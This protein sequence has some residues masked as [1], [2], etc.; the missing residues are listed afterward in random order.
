[1]LELE[2][3]FEVVGEAGNGYDLMELL[4]THPETDLVLL[5]LRMPDMSGFEALQKISE[6]DLCVKTVIMSM[7]DDPVYVTRAL[8]LGAAG[9]I[10][11]STDRLD[12][13]RALRSAMSGVPYVQGELTGALLS[14]PSCGSKAIGDTLAPREVHALQLISDGASNKQI[15]RELGISPATVKWYLKNS[16]GKLG[17]T[18]RAEAVATAL[19]LGIID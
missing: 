14:V 12:L 10:L 3:G 11:K 6:S 5:D 1:M 4:S 15:A 8:A 13:I 17:V 9:Y 18:S 16:F 19:R 2:P 7:H